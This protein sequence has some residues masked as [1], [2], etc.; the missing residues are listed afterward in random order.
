MAYLFLQCPPQRRQSKFKLSSSIISF[1]DCDFGL[2]LRILPNLRSWRFSPL[3]LFKILWFYILHSVLWSIKQCDLELGFLIL[4]LHSDF[5]VVGSGFALH[6]YKIVVNKSQGV[7]E[8]LPL[9]CYTNVLGLALSYPNLNMPTWIN[10]CGSGEFNS[11]QR[12]ENGM[13][14]LF[15]RRLLELL[16]RENWCWVAKKK[17]NKKQMSY[18][19][20]RVIKR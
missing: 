2:Y 15:Q 9:N 17:K 7:K 20:S 3:F 18:L 12:I 13:G 10:H 4:F 19:K 16:Y 11:K 1:M 14:K 6:Y 5:S 8:F